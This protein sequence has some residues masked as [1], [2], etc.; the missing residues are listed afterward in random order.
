MACTDTIFLSTRSVWKLSVNGKQPLS[1]CL[2]VLIASSGRFGLVNTTSNNLLQAHVENYFRCFLF[3]FKN[4][5]IK[6][7]V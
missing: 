5:A 3:S 4:S 2:V 1:L 7:S 6:A